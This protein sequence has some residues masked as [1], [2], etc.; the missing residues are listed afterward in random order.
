[1][2]ANARS[3]LF[4]ICATNSPTKSA[5][6]QT[7]KCIENIVSMFE[8]PSSMKDLM[9]SSKRNI[10]NGWDNE[11]L[12]T[13][14][15]AMAINEAIARGDAFDVYRRYE[16]LEQVDLKKIQQVAKKYFDFRQSTVGWLWP[17]EVPHE[18]KPSNYEPLKTQPF[19]LSSLKQLKH[20]EF[21]TSNNVFT[22]YDNK[23][24]DVRISV[25]DPSGSSVKNYITK[26]SVVAIDD[27]RI[28]NSIQGLL[29]RQVV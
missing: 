29:R 11:M 27:K 17:G 25:Q 19:V 9:E 1:M 5:L 28:Q 7:E 14:N 12:G 13:R 16:L 21:T 20:T 23:K 3:Y 8:N 22:K 6:Q 26:L 18:I 10:K 24:A 2:G 4:S 15:T